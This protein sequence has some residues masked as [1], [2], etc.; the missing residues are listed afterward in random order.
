MPHLRCGGGVCG[1]FVRALRVA[2]QHMHMV[3]ARALDD[4]RP[5]ISALSLGTLVPRQKIASGVVS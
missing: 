5:T 2:T 1:F 4:V 3:F